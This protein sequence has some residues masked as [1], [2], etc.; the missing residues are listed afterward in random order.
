MGD[1]TPG[2]A[3]GSTSGTDSRVGIGSDPQATIAQ[4]TKSVL[5]AQR[6]LSGGLDIEG[7]ARG[8][9]RAVVLLLARTRL[10]P[11]NG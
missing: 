3:G 9:R 8:A 5:E 1:P 10:V 11:A 2:T 7:P 4:C 6:R